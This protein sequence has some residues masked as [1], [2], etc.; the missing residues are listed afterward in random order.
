MA[1]RP[2]SVAW[3]D[4]E[5]RRSHFD[6]G[7]LKATSGHSEVSINA[8]P[9][10]DTLQHQRGRAGGG[11]EGGVTLV[12]EFAARGLGKAITQVVTAIGADRLHD[13]LQTIY[14]TKWEGQKW[15]RRG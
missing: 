9:T 7:T 14:I 8:P 13:I 4:N 1:S 11:G 2:A 6:P 15:T 5:A 10:G 3:C 12:P